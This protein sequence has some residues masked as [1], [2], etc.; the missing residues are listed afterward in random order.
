VRIFSRRAGSLLEVLLTA[1]RRGEREFLV[2]GD[3]RLSFAA[4]AGSVWGVAS[5]L[6]D[7]HGL[8]PGDRVAVL[9]PNSIDWLLA[10]FGSAVAGAIPVALNSWWR[11]GELDFA[12]RDSGARFLV[13]DESLLPR[14][15]SSVPALERVFVM[16]RAAGDT[17]PGLIDFAELQTPTPSP[18][19]VKIEESDPFAI[20]YTSGTTGPAKGCITTH[21]ATIAQV[22]SMILGAV[23]ERELTV[24]VGAGRQ[25]EA[26]K[27]QPVLLATSPLFH[28]SG[29]HSGICSALMTGSKVVLP[30]GQF[31]P[32]EALQLIQD[33]GVTAWG[34]VPTLIHR[35]VTCPDL[36]RFDLSSLESLSVGGA[37][38]APEALAR[39]RHALGLHP[40]IG[41][42]YGL[43]ETHGAITMNAGRS[44]IDRPSSVGR[45]GVLVDLKVV[46]EAGH[47]Q[48]PRGVGEVM[49]AG[50]LV[51]PGYWRRPEETAAAISD[52]W[53]RTGD[54]GFLDEDGYLYLVDRLKDVI[55]RG[56]ENVHCL[57]V[58]HCLAGHRAVDE[59]AVYGV[60]DED[61]GQRVVATV[62][63][64][65]GA[66]VS[67]GE[68]RAHANGKLASF[69]VP[70]HIVIS[71]DPLPR[72]AAGK[73]Q[74]DLLWTRSVL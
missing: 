39:A 19:E 36:D 63:L 5:S 32:V 50:A 61:L 58:E 59:A 46:D 62:H 7:R 67:G 16:G 20:V 70:D 9:G 18:P 74:K 40:K 65:H 10:A 22:Q 34:A 3:R 42:G 54:L 53:F 4:F 6:I 37:P 2:Q 51:T 23:I 28:V 56:G 43:T 30:T 1:E 38:I 47:P 8:C 60:P 45:A 73:V 66:Q 72:N 71:A 25:P 17:G 35:L 12:I 57:E 33:E 41:H 49:V 15:V 26:S 52:G 64:V 14:A 29:L 44:L 21:R 69:K 24:Q 13:V 31:D 68:L 11:S 48:P 55:I 27:R